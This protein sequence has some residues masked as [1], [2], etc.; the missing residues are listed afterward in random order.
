MRG[1]TIIKRDGT[2]VTT[3]LDRENED[4][5]DV[6]RLTERLGTKTGEEITGPDCD[7][8]HETTYS[9]EH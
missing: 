4:C 3:V 9:T 7:T 2:V 6:F 8:A 5:K 1:Q